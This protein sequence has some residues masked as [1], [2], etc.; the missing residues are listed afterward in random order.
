MT[1][2]LLI[3]IASCIKAENCEVYLITLICQIEHEFSNEMFFL[4]MYLASLKR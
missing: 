3:I 4:S 2:L 1:K